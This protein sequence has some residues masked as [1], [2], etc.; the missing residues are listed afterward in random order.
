MRLFVLK[1]KIGLPA[2]A[3]CYYINAF[4]NC[5]KRCNS[6]CNCGGVFQFYKG[7]RQRQQKQQQSRHFVHHRMQGCK[8]SFC[9]ISQNGIADFDARNYTA[10]YPQ[11]SRN[12]ESRQQLNQRYRCKSKIGHSIQLASKLACTVCFS[13][14]CAVY[15]I[16]N[17]TKEICDIKY[18]RKRREKQQ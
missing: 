8:L 5:G 16:A 9:N 15:H 12:R 10:P 11:P 3:I 7:Y 13:G 14:D 17:A 18:H 4:L 1:N 6:A 2:F